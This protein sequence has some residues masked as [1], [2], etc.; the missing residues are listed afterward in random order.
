[1]QIKNS[2]VGS[3]L[4]LALVGI[5]APALAD[6]LVVNLAGWKTYGGLGAALNTSALF[7]LASGAG[8]TGYSYTGLTFST[9]NGSFRDEFVISV[10]NFDGSAFMDW[11]PSVSVSGGTFGPASGSWGGASG[12]G[13]GATFVLT[14][15][16]NN[17]W[18][19]VYETT[20]DPFGD[21]GLVLD[22]TVSAGTLT[23][24]YTSPIPEPAS[25]GL[26]GLGLLGLS[27]VAGVA[28][29]R[30]A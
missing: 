1:M 28:R 25:W 4:A 7:T 29:R 2:I 26:M 24:F 8:I 12:S 20:D 30:R 18:V 22:A 15:G 9:S 14:P 10:N 13:A 19:T 23:V 21:A 27:G 17:L 5:S 16:A 3:A 11:A 6:E